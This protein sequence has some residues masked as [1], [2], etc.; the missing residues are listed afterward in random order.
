MYCVYYTEQINICRKRETGIGSLSIVRVEMDLCIYTKYLVPV[1][2]LIRKHGIYVV[3]DGSHKLLRLWTEVDTYV[4]GMGGTVS[5]SVRK[6]SKKQHDL[7]QMQF[8]P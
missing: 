5:S 7:A 4:A 8:G 2:I 1:L 6:R 3:V